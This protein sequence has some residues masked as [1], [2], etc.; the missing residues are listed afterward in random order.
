MPCHRSC[1]QFVPRST[2]PTYDEALHQNSSL[3]LSVGTYAARYQPYSLSYRFEGE[4][5]DI[6][7]PQTPAIVPQTDRFIVPPHFDLDDYLA[8]DSEEVDEDEDARDSDDE[9]DDDVEENGGA[10][11]SL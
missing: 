2:P 7:V 6:P 11:L 5:T 3:H 1:K 9:D 8:Y 4:Y 10:S